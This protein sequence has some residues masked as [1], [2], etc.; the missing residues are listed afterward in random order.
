[1]NYRERKLL[2][3]VIIEVLTTEGKGMT[4]AQ[5]K[6]EIPGWSPNF[7]PNGYSI[8]QMLRRM[9]EQGA[10][11]MKG[12]TFML[13]RK[14]AERSA[15]GVEWQKPAAQ[16][17]QPYQPVQSNPDGQRVELSAFTQKRSGRT[18]TIEQ[19]PT[20]YGDVARVELCIRGVWFPVTLFTDA[21]ICTG[22]GVPKWHTEQEQYEN[23][24]FMRII[25]K[26]GEAPEFNCHGRTITIAPRE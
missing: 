3:D 23:V 15:T 26:S 14:P 8:G 5:L 12:D 21:R 22:P 9:V 17:V 25:F 2:R 10:L 1:M 7:Y 18:I 4:H 11:E 19:E 13:T 20:E 24:E 16:Q 6:R